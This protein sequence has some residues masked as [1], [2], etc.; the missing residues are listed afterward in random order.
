MMQ[1]LS[2]QTAVWSLGCIES[3]RRAV[4]HRASRK[5]ILLPSLDSLRVLATQQCHHREECSTRFAQRIVERL[6]VIAVLAI[7]VR[8]HVL[9][10]MRF[11]QFPVRAPG[12]PFDLFQVPEREVRLLTLRPP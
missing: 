10:M 11:L 5:Q 7:M 4:E 3:G 12:A 2:P 1:L 9:E 6:P 8:D